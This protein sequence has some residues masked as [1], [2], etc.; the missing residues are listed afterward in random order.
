MCPFLR[1][2]E[3]GFRPNTMGGGPGRWP[4]PLTSALTPFP[5]P[6][7][8]DPPLQG[9][10]L[11][12]A[13]EYRACRRGYFPEHTELS[14]MSGKRA[15]PTA[16]IHTLPWAALSSSGAAPLLLFHLGS[17]RTSCSVGLGLVL[18]IV[19]L[20]GI[21]WGGQ[22]RARPSSNRRPQTWPS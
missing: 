19:S 3:F 20:D 4:Q 8:P 11:Y 1:S 7:R 2:Y 6:H 14:V 17:F 18:T 5:K 21:D 16:H 22:A 15:K 10:L 9:K 12:N 13:R